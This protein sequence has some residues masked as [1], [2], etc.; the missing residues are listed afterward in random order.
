MCFR[1]RLVPQQFPNSVNRKMTVGVEWEEERKIFPLQTL[2][3]EHPHVDWER[4]PVPLHTVNDASMQPQIVALTTMP[5][6]EPFLR[7]YCKNEVHM[8]EHFLSPATMLRAGQGD[9]FFRQQLGK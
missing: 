3:K 7:V 2:K 1:P 4:P 5:G 8:D 9:E 6:S